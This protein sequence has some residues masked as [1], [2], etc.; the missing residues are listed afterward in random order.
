MVAMVLFLEPRIGDG[1][2]MLQVRFA[3]VSGIVIG[4]RVTFA[5]KPVGEVAAIKEVRDARAEPSDDTGR[6]YFYQLAL[7]IDSSVDVYSSDEIAIRTTGLMGEKSI[8]ILP[9][10]AKE[11]KTQFLVNDQV[12]YANSVDPLEN[13]FSQISKVANKMEGAVD[14]FDKWFTSNSETLTHSLDTLDLVLG[15]SDTLL[16]TVNQSQLVPHLRESTDLLNDNLRFIRISLEDDQ[17]LNKIS[18]LASNLDRA[19][20]AFNTDGAMALRNINQMTR[21]L[22][23]GTGTIGRLISGEDIYLRLNS[24]MSKAETMMKDI[25][26]YGIL[27]QYDKSWQRSRTKK[28]NFLKALDTPREFRDYFEGEVDSMTTSLGR[29]T[30]LLERAEG[31]RAKIVE[32]EGFKR[33]FGSLMRTVQSLSD[34]LKLYNEGLVA[35]T[36]VE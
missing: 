22:A 5:G 7:K 18:S 9:K 10:A 12:I 33:Q 28:A 29:L 2:K 8:A 11:G 35:Q 30:E 4:T 34:S 15:Q 1:K 17:L 31:E 26:H 6:V 25:N 27:F 21:D 3:N 19:T 20:E 14:H 13:T 23:S 16:S 32:D 36:E 24:L